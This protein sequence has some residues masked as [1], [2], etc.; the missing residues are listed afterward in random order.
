[1]VK[2]LSTQAREFILEHW[3]EGK[4]RSH[5]RRKVFQRFGLWPSLRTISRVR[6][7]GAASARSGRRGPAPL[8][9][10]ADEDELFSIICESP[11]HM[12][13]E[14]LATFEQRTG[15]VM[16]Y[17]G[18]GTALKRL[19]ISRKK[20]RAFARKRDAAAS[21]AFRAFIASHFSPEML[22][23][24]DETAK[25]R[26]DL[27]R[28]WGYAARGIK[29][30]DSRG[31]VPRSYSCSSLCGFDVNG[32][33]NW[34]TIRNTFNRKAFLAACERT[35]FPYI[36]SF[37]GPRSVVI[38]DNAKIHHCHEFVQ[39]VNQC[40]GMVLFTPPYCFDCTP[41]DNGAFGL[42]K[43]YLQKHTDLFDSVP[44]ERALDEAFKSVTHGDARFCFRQC[45]YMGRRP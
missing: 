32:F 45:N 21:L 25:N 36:T 35:V 38:L 14:H 22:F 1:M 23:F 26:S 7:R 33:V 34:Y 2:A 44:L 24:L 11:Q 40:G 30:V 42:V 41:L 16:S 9:T 29:A 19:G 27:R 10:E 18:L 12:L 31:Y 8:L 17:S 37:P 4:E 39:R 43:R 3:R 13:K 28:G 20:L 6:A 15:I 5:I